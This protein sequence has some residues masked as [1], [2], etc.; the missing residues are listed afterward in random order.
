ESAVSTLLAG[1]TTM[2]VASHATCPVIAVPM[3]SLVPSAK[4]VVVGADGSELSEAAIGY[5]FQLA[6][7]LRSPLTGVHA[8]FEPVVGT[9]LGSALPVQHDPVLYARD[10]EI[11]LAESLAGWSEKYPDVDVRRRVVHGPAAAALVEAAVGAQLLVVGSRGRGVV[12]SLLLGSVS[13]AVLHLSTV[14]VAVVR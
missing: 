3:T 11:L 8:W 13:H 12:R 4:G 7:E 10:Q 5:A 2:Y 9:A 1:S 14:P 6:S